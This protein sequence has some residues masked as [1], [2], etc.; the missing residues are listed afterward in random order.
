M[1]QKSTLH[2]YFEKDF[3]GQSFDL[4]KMLWDTMTEPSTRNIIRFKV[5]FSLINDL[6]VFQ[7]LD[8]LLSNFISIKLLDFID[9]WGHQ[10]EGEAFLGHLMFPIELEELFQPTSF[11][12]QRNCSLSA[13]LFRKI[14]KSHCNVLHFS[15]H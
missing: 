2:S 7:Y 1:I 8:V 14:Q 5:Q 11:Q 12:Y 6:T 10:T 3:I 13:C 15:N 9:N 4:I